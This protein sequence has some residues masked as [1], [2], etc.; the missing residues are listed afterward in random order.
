MWRVIQA[1]GGALA[2]DTGAYV[3][4]YSPETI[5]AVT[6]LRDVYTNP[7]NA[8]ILPPGVNAWNDTLQQRGLPGRHASASPPTPAPCSPRRAST[9][10]RWRT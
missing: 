9:R 3:T 4:L 1:W 5:D 10:T 2:D 7:A 6:W 8:G